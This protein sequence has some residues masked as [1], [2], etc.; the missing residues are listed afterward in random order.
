MTLLINGCSFAEVWPVSNQ[1]ASTLGCSHIKNLGKR[2]TSFS[3]TIRTTIEWVAQNGNPT[4]VVIPIT[5]SHRSELSIA[6]KDN[7]LEGTWFPIQR[8]ELI[9]DTQI[10]EIVNPAM[11]KNYIDNYYGIIPDIRTHWD[12][13]FT[14]II[15]LC[16]FLDSKKIKYLMFDM[17]ND[18]K[19]SH[20][21]NFKS[22]SKI[23]FIESNQNIIDIFSFCGNRYMWNTMNESAKSK[24]NE[25]LHHHDA[26]Q[27]KCLEQKL[28]DYIDSCNK[29]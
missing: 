3:R 23:K 17:C 25:L 18:F 9:D 26:E 19:K 27:Y 22:F 7:E 16:S 4:M 10:N 28:L 6:K 20:I 12:L 21:E 13:I 15:S 29:K 8:K 2:G 11:V 24:T 1:F 14:Q 5:L